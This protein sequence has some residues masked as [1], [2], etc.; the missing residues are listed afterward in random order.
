MGKTATPSRTAPKSETPQVQQVEFQAPAPSGFGHAPDHSWLAGRLER[1]GANDHWFIR[2]TDPGE[3]DPF[4]G[5][6]ELLGT[7]PMAG[8]REGQAVRAE[9]ELVDPA[10]HETQPAYR[11]RAL[12]AVRP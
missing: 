7:G 2:Y 6:L 12:Q 3:R 9:G 11:V 4:G 5:R 1:D 8:F 10:P